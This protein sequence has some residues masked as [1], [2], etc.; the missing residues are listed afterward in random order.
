MVVWGRFPCAAGPPTVTFRSETAKTGGPGGDS[1]KASMKERTFRSASSVALRLGS[2]LRSGAGT[3]ASPLIWGG[4]CESA[5]CVSPV[6]V[7]GAYQLRTS[8]SSSF[9]ID[10][11]PLIF[12]DDA[13]AYSSS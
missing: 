8:I 6:L 9:D 7:I 2:C 12:W 1:P 10:P 11:R 4:T 13:R 5:M 3:G